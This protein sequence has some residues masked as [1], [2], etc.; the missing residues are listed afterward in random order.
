MLQQDKTE[1]ELEFLRRESFF[2]NEKTGLAYIMGVMNLIL[3][4]ISNPNIIKKN[5]LTTD[6]R[7]IQ[8]KDR[9]DIILANPPFGGKEKD[10]IQQNF[11]I[12]S[13]AT[14][15]LFLQHIM[16]Y[17]KV[18]GKA[19]IVIPEGVLFNTGNAFREIKKIMLEDFNLHSIVSL[20]AGV[21]LPYSGVKTN[22][23]FFDREGSTKDIWFYEI[24]LDRKLTKNKP[25]LYS[26][27]EHIPE[28]LK[29]R[30]L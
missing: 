8:E 9:F 17:M 13:N 23:I 3:H 18:S 30:E 16:K 24:N 25:L 15:M 29:K 19:A 28:L 6:V 10:T 14:E 20:P 1:K 22:V 11:P 2:G 27:I 21:F 26:E 7:Q 5:T 12:K 4:G